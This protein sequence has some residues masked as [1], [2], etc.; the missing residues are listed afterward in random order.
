[1]KLRFFFLLLIVLLIPISAQSEYLGELDFDSPE[2]VV[3]AFL[4]SYNNN[5]FF[6]NYLTLSNVTRYL[7]RLDLNMYF[8]MSTLA[9]DYDIVLELRDDMNKPLA[10][11]QYLGNDMIF[12]YEKIMM[13]HAEQNLHVINLTGSY[14][15]KRIDFNEDDLGEYAIIRVGMIDQGFDV[16]IQVANNKFGE[17]RIVLVE[18]AQALEEPIS[19]PIKKRMYLDYSYRYAAIQND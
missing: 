3:I 15:L 10:H 12:Y 1:M 11:N 19:W 2:K 4:D 18:Q 14:E 7:I 16:L 8:E 6:L 9:A 5:D 13:L 17:W